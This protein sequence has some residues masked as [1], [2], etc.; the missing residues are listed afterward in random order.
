MI[1]AVF[2]G[3]CKGVQ[4]G[5]DDHHYAAELE[6]SRA[7]QVRPRWEVAHPG[8]ITVACGSAARDGDLGCTTLLNTYAVIGRDGEMLDRHTKLI[9]THP[10]L[11]VCGGWRRS[12][13]ERR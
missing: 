13:S 1:L 5:L 7:R 3:G 9:P 6:P 8:R 2:S 4:Q 10:E 11:M 12:Q